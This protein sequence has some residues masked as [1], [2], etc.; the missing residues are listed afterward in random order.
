MKKNIPL[1]FLTIFIIGAVFVYF[2]YTTSLE[3]SLQSNNKL[4]TAQGKSNSEID[5]T[6]SMMKSQYKSAFMK[7]FL[8]LFFGVII[9]ALPAFILYWQQ[10]R[11][12]IKE[13]ETK[14]ISDTLEYIFKS[15]DSANNLLTDRSFLE[16]CKK[17]WPD[18]IPQVEKEMYSNFD[19][20]I[21]K[22]FFPNLMMRSFH[23]K[24]LSDQSFW[25][26][27][28][29]LMNIYQ[30]YTKMVMDQEEYS[31]LEKQYKL[32]MLSFIKKCIKRSKINL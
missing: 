14:I 18:K 13:E 12:Q 22:D 10:I 5:A 21:Q 27:F 11:N 9:G 4:L 17:E 29:E 8:I 20:A 15:N 30:N 24:R 25:K 2:N 28:E 1:L 16:K 31:E 7:D 3:I 23:L 32:L 19:K 26:E 6:I